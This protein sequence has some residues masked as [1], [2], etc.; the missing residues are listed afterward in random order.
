MNYISKSF[1]ELTEFLPTIKCLIITA[2]D[3]ETEELHKWMT[4]ISEESIIRIYEGNYTYYVGQLGELLVVHVQSG[5]G[6]ISASASIVTVSAAITQW[7]PLA[8]I[9]VGIA[10]GKDSGSQQIGD[11]LVSE[12]IIPYNIQKVTKDKTIQRGP[13]PPAG[14]VLFNRFKNGSKDWVHKLPNEKVAKIY[15]GGLL[16][17]E[18]LVDDKEY[19]DKLLFDNPTAIGGEM[20]GAG[21]FAAASG[22]KVEWIVVKGICDYGDGNK[23]VNKANYQQI[24]IQASVSLCHHICSVKTIFEALGIFACGT[25]AA[26]VSNETVFK[27]KIAAPLGKVLFDLYSPEKEVYYLERSADKKFSAYLDAYSI[28]ISG[29]SGCGKTT[30]I[31]RNLYQNK[32][33]FKFINLVHC[34]DFTVLDVFA[35]I[36]QQLLEIIDEGSS[37]REFDKLHKVL[38]GICSLVEKVSQTDE[39]IIFMEEIPLPDNPDLLKDFITQLNALLILN[40]SRNPNCN[41]KIVLSSIDSPSSYI[42]ASQNKIHE[43]FKFFHETNWIDKDLVD[44]I[45]LILRGLG[46]NLTEL[47]T[48]KILNA[49]KGSPRFVK[50]FIRDY[51]IVEP[52]SDS[53]FEELLKS[54]AYELKSNG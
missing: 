1:K 30:L 16:S 5:M 23:S 48:N 19:R 39:L 41:L 54:V 51:M 9:M 18:S 35:E 37:P 50:N 42:S 20:E 26:I 44:L 12:T 11:V 10:F 45:A 47:E 2:T 4:P 53:D 32:K 27:S 3:V 46:R 17:G 14:T 24:A 31:L 28:W 22:Q 43:I 29:E 6:S 25:D 52:K 21:L 36:Y 33:E 7:H 34:V 13:V 8:V 38:E 40:R 49:S 15:F